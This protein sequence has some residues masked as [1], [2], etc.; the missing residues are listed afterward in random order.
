[1]RIHLYLAIGVISAGVLLN[2]SVV[3][4]TLLCFTIGFVLAAELTNTALEVGLDYINGRKFDPSIRIVKDIVAAVVLIASV[5]AV[6][7][8]SIIFIPHLLK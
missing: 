8:G 1:M 4:I 7:V 3:E 2:L 5:N 6:V